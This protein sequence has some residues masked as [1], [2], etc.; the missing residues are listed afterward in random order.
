MIIQPLPTLYVISCLK[1]KLHSKITIQKNLRVKNEIIATNQDCLDAMVSKSRILGF[2]T[3]VSPVIQHDV[4]VSAK[5]LVKMIPKSKRSCIIGN[6]K[7]SGAFIESNSYGSEEIAHYLKNNNSNLFF[8]KY[9]G[10]IKT[11]HTRTNLMDFG[12]ILKY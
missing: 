1:R 7:Y 11:G 3:I 10:L 4:S 2:K 6:T 5:I 12:L 8:K 9:A